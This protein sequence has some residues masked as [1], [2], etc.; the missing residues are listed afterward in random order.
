MHAVIGPNG[1]G[2]STFLATLAGDLVADGGRVL[3]TAKDVTGL[4]VQPRA[5]LGVGRTY[6]RSAVIARLHGARHGAAGGHSEQLVVGRS[7]APLSSEASGHIG[8]FARPAARRT[9][10]R[11]EIVTE[12][13]SHGEKRRLEI[14]AVLA[15]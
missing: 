13:L 5:H 7:A 14:A 6:Q 2:K 15:L 8:C 1:A 4:S 3:L 12:A 10:G 9:G 11:E